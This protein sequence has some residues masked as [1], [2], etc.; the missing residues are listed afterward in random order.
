MSD[1]VIVVMRHIREEG[2]CARGARAWMSHYG[3]D[4]RDFL[5]NGLRAEELEATGDAF[6]LRVCARARKEKS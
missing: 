2:L 1:E 4:F 5:K 6:A 3:F